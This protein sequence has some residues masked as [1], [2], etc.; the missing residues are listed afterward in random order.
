MH[1]IVQENVFKEE[2]YNNLIKAL[3]RFNL[4][5][6]IVKVLPFIETIDFKYKG[7]DVFP[8]GSLKMARISQNLGW[9]PGS[10]M[11]E[12]HDYLVYKDYYKEELLNYDS[13]IYKFGDDFFSKELFF[14]RPTKDTKVFTGRV[15]DMKEWR[16]FRE[17]ALKDRD[18]NIFNKNTEIQISSVKNIQQEIRCWIV[19]GN[20]I[21]TS[22]YKLGGRYCLSDIIDK[23]ALDYCKRM[24]DI[25]QLNEAFVMDICLV[26][27]KYKIVE[28]G[29][30]N[31]A[32]FYK[33][34]LQK[35]LMS[36]ELTF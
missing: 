13:K 8:F 29:C 18:S 4:S 22:Q 25:F 36:I 5:Y 21:T 31:C 30:I 17:N 35:L 26:D 33:A 3:D 32:G 11:N 14:A 15:F 34:D 2:N 19:K 20:I 7:L 9:Y 27:N 10:Q 12:N 6:E 1:Y 16:E 23:S 24:V 28:C